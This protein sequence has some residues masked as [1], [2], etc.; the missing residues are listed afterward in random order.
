MSSSG[1]V[2]R[3]LAEI[4]AGSPRAESQLIPLVYDELRRLA[5]HY[6]R[7]ERPSH[8][9]QATALVNEAYLRLA[10]QREVS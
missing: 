2:T 3:L 4:R 9:L 10:K 6:M 1:D 7:Q 8:T 5:G